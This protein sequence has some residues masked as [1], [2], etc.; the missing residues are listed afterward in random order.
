MIA[1]IEAQSSDP[2]WKAIGNTMLYLPKVVATPPRLPFILLK[3]Q[4]GLCA[5]AAFF[6]ITRVPA[7]ACTF[8]VRAC[9]PFFTAGTRACNYEVRS[10]TLF[11]VT[12][13]HV[14]NQQ[15]RA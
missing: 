2:D 6:L 9:T 4:M 10:C 1:A 7:R 5:C 12:G 8:E 14:S 15:V 11:F 13:T 3:P